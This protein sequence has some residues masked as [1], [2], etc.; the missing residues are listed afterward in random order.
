[1]DYFKYI[2]LMCL[3]QRGIKRNTLKHILYG[4]RTVYQMMETIERQLTAF[5][6]AF[7]FQRYQS[8]DLMV[9]ELIKLN[10]VDDSNNQLILTDEGSSIIQKNESLKKYWHP[11]AMRYQLIDQELFSLC[12][13]I[14]QMLSFKQHDLLTDY[15]PSGTY[16]NQLFI[17]NLMHHKKYL[18]EELVKALVECLD[19][20]DESYQEIIV[21]QLVGAKVETFSYQA[22]EQVFDMKE[23][24]MKYLLWHFFLHVIDHSNELK[25]MI[26]TYIKKRS[27]VSESV[28][29]TAHL[30]HSGETVNEIALKRRLKDS[31]IIDHLFEFQLMYPTFTFKEAHDFQL[32][33]EIADL[34]KQDS[35]LRFGE[36]KEMLNR[37][38]LTYSYILF[39]K[40]VRQG[41]KIWTIE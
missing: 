9:N 24:E 16:L 32:V 26:K 36:I 22:L 34:L 39:A 19:H 20:Y 11:D 18:S 15:R 30:F 29:Y 25:Q 27:I 8:F 33:K 41:D 37:P 10:Y 31:T 7:K 1:M 6:G 4:K 21:S 28:E 12:L 13:S 23:A 40:L 17:H 35:H 5:Y 14:Y 2:V 38:E 3:E